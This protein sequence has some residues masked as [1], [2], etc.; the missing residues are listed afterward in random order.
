M[1]FQNSLTRHFPSH[2]LASFPQG[3]SIAYALIAELPAQGEDDRIEMAQAFVQSLT[4]LW[5]VLLGVAVVGM[6]VSLL[7]R[8]LPL[9]GVVHEEWE[10]RDGVGREGDSLSQ[11]VDVKEEIESESSLRDAEIANLRAV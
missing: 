11:D 3:P 2:F 8:G 10:L 1:V 9:H 6:G 5:Y 7:M 4:L